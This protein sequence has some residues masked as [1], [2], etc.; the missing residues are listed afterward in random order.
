M[1]SWVNFIFNEAESDNESL[2]HELNMLNAASMSENQLSDDELVNNVKLDTLFNYKN[3]KSANTFLA[4]YKCAK[5]STVTWRLAIALANARVFM[6][7]QPRAEPQLW[8]EFL[9]K[10]REKYEKMETVE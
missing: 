3:P 10:L 6:S 4:P 9:L 5:K 7:D 1:K 8:V 2:A